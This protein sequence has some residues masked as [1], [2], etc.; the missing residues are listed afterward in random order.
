MAEDAEGRSF[1]L[2]VGECTARIFAVKG[3]VV[4]ADSDRVACEAGPG[5]CGRMWWARTLYSLRDSATGH[6][7]KSTFGHLKGAVHSERGALDLAKR[8]TQRL[9]V[10]QVLSAG[11]RTETA[12]TL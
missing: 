10:V 1:H 12:R 2:R 4:A 11:S 7:L 6:G 5:G 3:A 8:I 9:S